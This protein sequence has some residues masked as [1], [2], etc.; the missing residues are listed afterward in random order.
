MTSEE[1][2]E[3]RYQRRKTERTEKK[4]CREKRFEDVFTFQN[5][6]KGYLRSRT[7]VM[8]KASTQTYKASALA[9]IRKTQLQLM[10]GKWKSKGFCNFD[11]YDR[12][13]LR[14]IRSVHIA[15][16]V[17]QHTLC[18]ELLTPAITPSLIYDN[19][20][21]LK[22]KGM[23]FALQRCRRHIAEAVRKHDR[24][25]LYVLVYDFKGYFDNI[26][27]DEA[28]RLQM[29]YVSDERSLSLTRQLVDDFGE[30]GVGLGSQ[31][32][33]TIATAI[34]NPLDHAFKQEMK[35]RW[36][37]R[38]MDDG[39]AI[40]ESCEH[41][42]HCLERLRQLCGE[43]N[44]PLNEG[45]TKI[46][47]LRKGFVFLK[48]RFTITETGRIVQRASRK[49]IVRERRKI[50]KLFGLL[51]A[52]KI[53]VK[54]IETTMASMDGHLKR[55]DSYNARKNLQALYDRKLKE[56]TECISLSTKQTSSYASP[57]R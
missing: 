17:V 54:D 1:R 5:L 41:L 22:G 32:S 56:V 43:R 27:H 47:S 7:G 46:V 4:I 23:D 50:T 49:T 48:M 24:D 11:L 28:M 53:T 16:R 35:I 2:R 15:E 9:N 6:Y 33:Q 39:Y 25:H 13:K 19:S 42:E 38:Y 44:I 8:W 34:P 40:H 57:N 55:A 30:V 18:D 20:G 3:A 45:K 29:R 31:V 37:G 52:G 36:Y 14:H 12:G 10:D 26:D 51:K 21:S